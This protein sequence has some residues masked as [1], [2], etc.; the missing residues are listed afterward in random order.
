MSWLLCSALLAAGTVAIYWRALSSP[1]LQDD[2]SSITDNPSLRRLWPVATVLSP[3]DEAGVGGRPLLNLSYA[4]NYAANGT[5][6]QGYHLANIAIHILA[7]LALFGLV[8]RTLRRPL[9]ADTFGPS[10]TWL[11]F[12]VSAIWAWHP[13]QTESVTYISQ[14]AESLMGLFYLLTLYCVVRGAEAPS[15]GSRSL[16]YLFSALSCIAGAAT[17][18]VIVTAPVVALLYDRTF[19]SGSLRAAWRRNWP[20]YTAL[21]LSWVLLVH[22]I[23]S[24]NNGHSAFGVGFARGI[25][26]WDYALAE[27]R[28]VVKYL[29]LACWPSPLVFD[30]GRNLPFHLSEIWPYLVALILM[31]AAS[32]FALWRF[33]SIGFAACWYFLILAPTSSIIPIPGQPM[34][35]SRMYLPLI[36]L[37][38]LAVLGGF[39]LSGGA[40]MP[41][42]G[43]VAVCMAFTAFHRN[44]DYASE[45]TIWS[46]TVAKVPQ[47]ARAHGNLGRVLARIPGRLDA[48]AIEYEA[49]IDLEPGTPELRVNLGN[50]LYQMPN[51]LDDAIAQYEEALRLK[52][53]DAQAH[54]NLGCALGRVQGQLEESI[55]QYEQAIRLRPDFAP[56][57][58]NLGYSLLKIPGRAQDA[59][60]QF[61]AGLQLNPDLAEA[62]LGLATALLQQ[63]G[64]EDEARVHLREALRLD[65]GNLRARDMLGEIAAPSP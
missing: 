35:E 18:E 5:S 14:R 56:A 11:A 46:D 1:F 31:V 37:A 32:L 27:C 3:P 29:L 9:L 21:A 22:R 40:C 12:L 4:V 23:Y 39:A 53:D 24:L 48:A 52:P 2:A 54:F 45:L 47:N 28:V 16:W 17:K 19:L 57:R 15:K 20:L 51:R 10:S 61:A 8:R 36:G 64:R 62:H 49:A 7:S 60:A 25:S 55:A 59:A 43:A 65:P 33:P 38:A 44:S 50:I 41:V 13:L 63:P 58:C 34:A 42:F 26:A 30:Y 6:V